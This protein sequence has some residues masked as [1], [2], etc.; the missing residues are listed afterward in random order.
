MRVETKHALPDT[1]LTDVDVARLT[2]RARKT[3][4]KDR[5]R[6]GDDCIPFIRLGRLVRYRQS[7]V[8]EF[9]ARRPTLRSTTGATASRAGPA[10]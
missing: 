10:A 1:L 2:G 3:I 6:G 9:I 7:D 5:L 4:Q 8:A